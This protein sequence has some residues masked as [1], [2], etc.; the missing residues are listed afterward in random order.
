M[1]NKELGIYIHIPFCK[2]KCYYCDFV[3]FSDKNDLEEKYIEAIKKE[4]KYYLD[5]DNFVKKYNVTTI[6][7]GGGTPSY[8]NSKYILE[9][10]ELLQ[11]KLKNNKTKFENIEITIE[12]N[13]GT[14]DKQKLEQYK[15]AKINRLSIGLQSANNEILKQIGRIHT[16]EQF[17]ETYNLAEQVGFDN[18]NVDLMIGLPNQSIE[19][20]KNSLKKVIE[21]KPTHVSVYSLIIE[22]G[23]VIDKLIKQS[24]LQEMKEEQERRMYWY[25]KSMLELNG[26]KHYEI[27]NFAKEGKESKHNVNCWLQKEY[28]GIGTSA[29]SY[30]NGI[31]YSNCEEI[32]KYIEN[33]E[34]NSQKE[35]EKFLDEIQ[36]FKYENLT[37]KVDDGKQYNAKNE[38]NNKFEYWNENQYNNENKSYNKDLYNSE[39]QLR[40]KLKK[41]K[42]YEIQEIQSLDDM[43]KEYMLL[44]LRKIDGVQISKFKEKYLDNPI[45]TYRKE[46]EKLVKEKLIIID[47]DYIKLTNQGL[48]LANLVW[49]EFV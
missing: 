22:E 48:D 36:N 37:N 9:I 4:I 38:Y 7:I 10:L 31:R 20:V 11:S 16:F 25:V 23:T 17:L 26:Y 2:Q 24:I 29:H 33:I 18:I 34:E 13:P 3:S 27:S 41:Q 35:F 12:V 21:L 47:G 39:I 5:N 1:E 15:K 19:D 42:L 28:I 14:V 8:I 6:Y 49:E 30:L 44:G 40:E 43:K 45:F 32:E 46:L